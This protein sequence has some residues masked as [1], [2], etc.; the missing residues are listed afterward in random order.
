[1]YDLTILIIILLFLVISVILLLIKN[2]YRKSCYT[3]SY[4]LSNV[5]FTFNDIKKSLN[6]CT[7]HI[8]SIDAFNNFI[9]SLSKIVSVP[10][11]CKNIDTYFDTLYKN[12]PDTPEGFIKRLTFISSD[13]IILRDSIYPL[14]LYDSRT[15]K[16]TKVPLRNSPDG[17]TETNL[18]R[19][20]NKECYFPYI[21]TS[22]PNGS[23]LWN[24]TFIQATNQRFEQILAIQN[25]GYA[26]V[27]RPDVY[28]KL[29]YFV[30][31]FQPLMNK[32]IQT[33][34][35]TVLR[36]SW[37]PNSQNGIN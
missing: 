25:K 28:G 36:L 12:L 18:Y 20:G 13:G 23:L 19:F 11:R 24:S 4:A 21:D 14:K 33:G 6:K 22:K 27:V 8:E 34:S 1:M 37:I 30:S 3:F 31:K 29:N 15:K 7:S 2:Y 16:P 9:E 5:D 26:G 32:K 17:K 35:F 10:E